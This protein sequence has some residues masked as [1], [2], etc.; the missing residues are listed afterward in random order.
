MI[1]DD[2]PR[3]DLTVRVGCRL[4]YETAQ[5]VPLLLNVKPRTGPRQSLQA[6]RLVFGENL[7]SEEFEDGH[8]NILYRMVLLPGRHEILHDA[9][10]SVPSVPDNYN[11]GNAEPVPLTELSPQML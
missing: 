9:L 6:E 7:P 11:F 4:V 8:G 5:A 2:A 1:I 3:L 10:V